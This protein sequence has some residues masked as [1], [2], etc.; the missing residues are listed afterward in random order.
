MLSNL[1]KSNWTVIHQDGTRVID[2]NALLEEK[3]RKAREKMR[4]SKE[5][6]QE[7]D[8]DGFRDGL[9]AEKI[10]VLLAPDPAAVEE[11]K[12]ERDA[13]LAEI[14]QTQAELANL[15]SQADTMIDDAKSQ[16]ASMQMKA[17]EEAKEQGHAEGK[18]IGMKEAEA[19]RQE[20]LS[21]IQ[22]NEREYERQLQG[23]EPEFVE[24][25]TGIYEHIFKVDLSRYRDL[26]SNLLVSAM[27][28]IEDSRN[29]LVH[30][31]KEDYESVSASK[32]YIRSEAGSAVTVEIVEDVTLSRSQCMIE[33]ENGVYDCS[34]DTQLAELGR[35]LKLL[36]Y[37]RTPGRK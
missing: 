31:S 28:K 10:D 6:A 25:L 32:E 21:K 17:Y 4:H 33:T 18:R 26:V 16:I 34:L 7:T 22:E 9:D 14:E 1:Y 35:K 27:Q 11:L 13:L 36:S 5:N 24:T 23:L 20:Y 30:V 8:E 29:F 2:N 15:K 19:V 12:R 3:L 37:E